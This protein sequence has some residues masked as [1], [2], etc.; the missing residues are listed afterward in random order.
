MITRYRKYLETL[1][2]K[3]SQMFEKQAPF[4]KCKKGCA[5]CCKDGEFPMSELEYINIMLKY[6]ELEYELKEKVDSNINKLLKSSKTKLYECPFL[7]DNS[8][9]VYDARCIICR[10]LGL[11]SY[12]KNEYSKIPFCVDLDL[13]FAEVYDKESQKITKNERIAQ[14]V[15]IPYMIVDNFIVVEE[16]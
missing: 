6:D 3:L 1:D 12:Y 2:T 11:I 4:I 13:N 5:Y 15:I 8:C 9:S 16:L 7:I 10:T 14:L